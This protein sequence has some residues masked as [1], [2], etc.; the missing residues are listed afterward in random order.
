MKK[1]KLDV[2]IALSMM[3]VYRLHSFWESPYFNRGISSKFARNSQYPFKI[4]F[5]LFLWV[6][7]RYWTSRR[8]RITWNLP[9]TIG[10]DRISRFSKLL[11]FRT[12]MTSRW[13][14]VE[15]EIIVSREVG[16]KQASS[17]WPRVHAAC[18]G[19]LT[20]FATMGYRNSEKT[21]EIKLKLEKKL[22]KWNDALEH[23]QLR[24]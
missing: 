15:I 17:P 23:F 10:L 22:W 14:L 2:A 18:V 11:I 8:I 19:D 5:S 3:M 9:E 24:F 16:R 20:H 13:S 7:F 4:T 6:L 12:L 21:S 1:M